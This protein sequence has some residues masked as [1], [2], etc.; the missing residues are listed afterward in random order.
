MAVNDVPGTQGLNLRDF[1][2]TL[3]Q[4]D[5]SGRMNAIISA[6]KDMDIKSTVQECRGLKVKNV[7][8]DFSQNQLPA[9][10][11]FTAHYDKVAGSPGAND[12]GSGVSVLLGLCRK[13]KHTFAPVRAVFFD[14]EEAWFKTPLLKLG[15]LG[16]FC[17]I[18][19]EGRNKIE[20]VYN[21]EFCG[22]GDVVTLWPVGKHDNRRT[23]KRTEEAANRLSLR[24]TS[25]YVPWYIISGDHLPFRL[26]GIDA[27]TL[28]ML[29]G[30]DLE[31]LERSFKEYNGNI[32]HGLK[33]LPGP[34]SAIHTLED[35]SKQLD[36]SAL[37][38]MLSLMLEIVRSRFP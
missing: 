25:G 14:R 9:T 16:S 30:E 23:I 36:E 38:K 32:F 24:C 4:L 19:K 12:D 7:V 21:L 37:R 3:E 5:N 2:R 33:S 18:H 17:Y 34:L 20:E 8:V 15:L 1:V 35:N 13:M 31:R 26:R 10:M 6:L 22:R 29:P 28:S 27:I 11:L